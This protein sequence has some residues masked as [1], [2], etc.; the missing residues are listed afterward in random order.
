VHAPVAL[1]GVAPR[2]LPST[3]GVELRVSGEGFFRSR[4]LAVRLSQL[5]LADSS[6]AHLCAQAPV[7][8]GFPGTAP[9]KFSEVKQG[10]VCEAPPVG[11]SSSSYAYMCVLMLLCMCPHTALYEAPPAGVSSYAY[12]CPHTAMYVSSYCYICALM[13]LHMCPHTAIYVS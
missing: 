8:A 3:G 5:E 12:I 2:V 1:R 7:I 6:E 11:V 9:A 4:W 13:L 10:V